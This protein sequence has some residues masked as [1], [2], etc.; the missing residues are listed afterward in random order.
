MKLEVR[1]GN[2]GYEKEPILK[3]INFEIRDNTIMTI[4]GPNGV[5]KTTLLKCIMGFLKWHSG[6]NYMDDKPL[7]SYSDKVFWQRTSYVPQAKQSVY[8]YRVVDTV[9]MGLNAK[10]NFFSMPKAEDYDKA[11]HILDMLGVSKLT[12]KYCNELSGGE[13]QMVMMARALIS[14]P[15]L[16]IL[17]EPESNLDMKN[18]LQIMNT[19]EKVAEEFNTSCLINTHFPNHALKISDTTLML[20]YGNKQVVGKT[21]DVVTEEN[22]REYFNVCSRVVSLQVDA[23][24]YKTIFPY[25]IA[26][27]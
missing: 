15:E 7:S 14:E 2:F 8:S 21:K 23:K 13:L 25:Q 26:G 18:Q 5:G 1:N 17:D 9:M 19:I 10:Q 11:V 12:E 3:D 22:I 6:E 24:E 4:L 27:V 20:G 16:M